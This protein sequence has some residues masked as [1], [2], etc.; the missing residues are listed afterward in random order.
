MATFIADVAFVMY[1]T[2]SVLAVNNDVHTGSRV[3]N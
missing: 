1:A 3:C 2:C